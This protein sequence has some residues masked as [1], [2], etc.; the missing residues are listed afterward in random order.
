MQRRA[1]RAAAVLNAL[2]CEAILWVLGLLSQV[3]AK[4]K[5]VVKGAFWDAWAKICWAFGLPLHFVTDIGIC[6]WV[7]WQLFSNNIMQHFFNR[8]YHIAR[9]VEWPK[10]SRHCGVAYPKSEL[11]ITKTPKWF[12]YAMRH[13]MSSYPGPMLAILGQLPASYLS[14]RTST[15]DVIKHCFG[16]DPKY[17]V[18]FRKEQTTNRP[19]FYLCVDKAAKCIVVSVR[20]TVPY[21]VF[22]VMTDLNAQSAQYLDGYVHHG[23]FLAAKNVLN[24]I[25]NDK[26]SRDLLFEFKHFDVFFCGHSLGAGVVALMALRV[27]NGE[28]S[29]FDKSKIRTFAFASPGVASRSLI[30]MHQ[31]EMNSVVTSVAL[32]TDCVTRAS[33]RSFFTQVERCECISKW[34]KEELASAIQMDK[35]DGDD[36][37]Q[38]GRWMIDGLKKMGETD[39]QMFPLGEVLWYV[40]CPL[41]GS[42]ARAQSIV[43]KDFPEDKDL[44]AQGIM[45]TAWLYIKAIASAIKGVDSDAFEKYNDTRYKLCDATRFK[46]QIFQNLIL[47]V[48]SLHAH[49]P[50]RYLWACGTKLEN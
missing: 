13:A 7:G 48:E 35:G 3:V 26:K 34:D 17:I 19:S 29:F 40:P 21:N 23:M 1:K 20:G 45:N 47:D 42:D 41:Q 49:S 28:A 30:E 37:E 11:P 43:V 24:E 15:N 32:S 10:L 46:Q 25:R 8:P 4:F 36:D 50:H 2:V 22:D 33:L 18:S 9:C 5:T 16:I 12:E 6:V 44:H 27:K 31:E 39:G 38:R 14:P